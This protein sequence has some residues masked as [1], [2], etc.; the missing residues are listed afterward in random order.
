MQR[1]FLLLAIWGASFAILAGGFTVYFAPPVLSVPQAAE[2]DK[3]AVSPVSALFGARQLVESRLLVPSDI[4]I[5]GVLGQG[6]KGVVVLSI[7]NGPARTLKVGILEPD[8]LILHRIDPH[9]VVLGQ[10]G[11]Q[12]AVSVGSVTPP[13]SK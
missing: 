12:I 4:S 1:Y 6:E 11:Q 5:L 10:F 7:S 8:G 3:G 2:R 9:Q 13:L